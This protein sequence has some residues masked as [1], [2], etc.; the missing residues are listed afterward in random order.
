M[1]RRRRSLTFTLSSVMINLASDAGSVEDLQAGV[2]WATRLL[3]DGEAPAAL[4]AQAGYNRANGLEGIFA[5]EEAG[6]HEPGAADQPALCTGFQRTWTRCRDCPLRGIGAKPARSRR[7]R[8]G[9]R[10][11]TSA[12]CWMTRGAGW[13]HRL[14]GRAGGRPDQRKRG[15]SGIARAARGAWD[16]G[17]PAGAPPAAVY[18]KY[19]AMAKSLRERTVEVGRLRCRRPVGRPRTDREPGRTASMTATSSTPTSAGSCG[20]GSP[21]VASVEAS[22]RT[23]GSGTP[24]P[25]PVSCHAA[26]ERVTASS[27][28]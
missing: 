26:G 17:R 24:R 5:A 13:R 4:V 12:T 6:G 10:C 2:T 7:E 18:D 15:R 20:T 28:R 22:A 16:L 9:W 23:R 14:R 19:A 8:A 1:T 25:C 11:A 3:H 21:S 27:A